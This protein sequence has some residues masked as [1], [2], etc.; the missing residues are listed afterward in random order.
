MDNIG[1]LRNSPVARTMR[2]MAITTPLDVGVRSA[3]IR[4]TPRHIDT[5]PNPL[6]CL[7][8]NSYIPGRIDDPSCSQGRP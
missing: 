3:M 7:S 8:K 6:D 1:D 2:P 5:I 4:E